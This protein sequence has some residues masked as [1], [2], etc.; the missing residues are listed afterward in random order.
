MENDLFDF[1]STYMPLL[2]EEKKAIMYLAI[3]RTY[4]KAATQMAHVFPV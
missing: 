2:D 3:F 4:K 1:I